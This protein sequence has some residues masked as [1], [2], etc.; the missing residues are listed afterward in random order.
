METGEV[1]A[2]KIDWENS[3]FGIWYT[4]LYDLDSCFGAEN[5]GYIRIPY[6]ADWNYKLGRTGTYQFNGHDSRFWCMFEE[7]FA[8]EIKARAQSLTGQNEGAEGPLNYAVLRQVHITDNAELVCPA[9]VNEDMEYKYEDAWTKGYW[10]YS[11][12]P[13][14]PTWTQTDQY[15]YLQRGSRTE[16]KESFIYRRSMML[17]S[18]YQ[19]SQF[20][21]NRLAFRCG[22]AVSKDDTAI[23]LRAIQA[24]Y[25]G[26]QFGDSG[27][28]VMSDKKAADEAATI[29]AP[30]GLGRSDN[31]YIMGAS[32]LTS[33]SSLAAFHPYEIGL[34]NAGKLKTLLIGSHEQGYPGHC[35]NGDVKPVHAVE[36][37][38]IVRNHTARL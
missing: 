38:I 5:S 34:T 22:S 2:S 19:C 9:V 23:T 13:D 27:S 17:Y 31:C 25:M 3:T 20:T 11:E 36:R 1:D 29:L 8:D 28:P 15:K 12:D 16:Q 26:V 32:N 30:N 18:K 6:Y 10:D 33:V 24:M 35:R 21:N 14:N 37:P 4:D 7:A